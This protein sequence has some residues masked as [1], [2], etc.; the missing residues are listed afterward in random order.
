MG[1]VGKGAEGGGGGLP[2]HS[3]LHQCWLEISALAIS[4][5]DAYQKTIQGQLGNYWIL[6]NVTWAKIL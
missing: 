5:S 6:R 1:V 4:V 3:I 2:P